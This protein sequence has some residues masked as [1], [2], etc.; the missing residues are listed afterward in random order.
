MEGF[1]GFQIDLGDDLLHGGTATGT[2]LSP[3]ATGLTT[4]EGDGSTAGHG[5][6]GYRADGLMAEQT[7]AAVAVG[8][9]DVLAAL[10]GHDA[11][12]TAQIDALLAPEADVGASDSFGLDG[13]QRATG[14]VIDGHVTTRDTDRHVDRNTRQIQGLGRVVAVRAGIDVD[15]VVAGTT[16]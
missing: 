12:G 14:A 13:L 8:A 16:G 15:S 5:D 7:G 9:F 4:T 6:E 10:I 3:V 1:A 2:S 11:V